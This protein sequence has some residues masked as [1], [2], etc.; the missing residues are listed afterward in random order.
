MTNVT[1]D[2]QTNTFNE[3]EYQNFID[4]EIQATTNQP[5]LYLN[6]AHLSTNGCTFRNWRYS[7]YGSALCGGP[8]SIISDTGSTFTQNLGISG[9]ALFSTSNTI[10]L[11]N[12]IFS[13]NYAKS[14]GAI[15]MDGGSKS[16]T[17]SGMTLNKNV[18]KVE[19]ACLNLISLSYAFISSSIFSSNS[20]SGR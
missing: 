3:I 10:N 17:F 2:C 19:G 8:F 13:Y 11:T 14:G 12:S 15:T 16:K 5:A 9:G 18:V 6:P 7:Q 20:C 1:V 4:N